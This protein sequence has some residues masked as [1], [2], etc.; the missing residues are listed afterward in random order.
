MYNEALKTNI[1]HCIT[2]KTADKGSG[3][4]YIQLLT[5]VNTSVSSSRLDV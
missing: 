1:A 5:E 3:S 4:T 2:D